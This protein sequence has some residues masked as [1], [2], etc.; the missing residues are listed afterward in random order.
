MRRCH[1]RRDRRWVASR[2][3]PTKIGAGTSRRITVWWRW[4]LGRCL[5]DSTRTF[6][7]APST[8]IFRKP[9]GIAACYWRFWSILLLAVARQASTL[10]TNFRLY[11]YVLRLQRG[12]HRSLPSFPQSK[13]MVQLIEH[14]SSEVSL[15]LLS[16]WSRQKHK[17]LRIT[18]FCNSRVLT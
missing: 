7:W 2:G 6:Q 17:D 12:D 4:S 13:E 16:E 1:R 15:D 11:S 8:P 5:D 14:S 3:W 9:F 18:S 10:S